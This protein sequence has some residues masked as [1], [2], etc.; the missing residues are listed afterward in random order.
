MANVFTG[1][2]SCR[3]LW[4]FEAV[5]GISQDSI[6]GNHLFFTQVTGEGV[7]VKEGA[8]S[9][10]FAR[11]DSSI[12][13]KLDSG[14]DVGFPFRFNDTTPK[15]DITVCSWVYIIVVPSTDGDAAHIFRKFLAGGNLRTFR[16]EINNLSDKLV[17]YKGYNNGASSENDGHATALIA[18]RW[19]HITTAYSES[20]K[21]F[22]ISIWDDTAGAI[23]GTNK[24]SN[25]AQTTSVRDVALQIGNKT[26]D[27]YLDEFVVFNKKKTLYDVN[28]IRKGTYN[29][30][31]YSNLSLNLQT[32]TNMIGGG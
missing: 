15:K 2:G 25:F 6:G 23:H 29:Y 13:T 22:Y 19:Y 21:S 28:R 30:K 8:Q 4:R 10:K 17:V 31:D 14:L 7:I 26:S 18:G 12:A 24:I 9:A 32:L 3:T 27:F 1:D 16:I 20:D 5:P 11:A